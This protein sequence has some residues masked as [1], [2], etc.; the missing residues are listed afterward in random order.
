VFWGS[1]SPDRGFVATIQKLFPCGTPGGA[2][3]PTRT[4]WTM[5]PIVKRRLPHE[6]RF[7]GTLSC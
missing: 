5:E 7:C 1:L 2:G 3:L 6:R 4:H